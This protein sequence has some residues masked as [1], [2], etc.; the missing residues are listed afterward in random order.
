VTR[1]QDDIPA[2]DRFGLWYRFRT[3]VVFNLLYVAGPAQL[4]GHKDP[5][6]AVEHDYERR[7]DLHRARRGL[8]PV[9][10]PADTKGGPDVVVLLAL[11]GVVALVLLLVWG[12]VSA[13]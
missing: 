4:D 10:K 2:E 12:I 5:R 11:A 13:R 8:P 6:K 1:T 7:R 9:V 3:L